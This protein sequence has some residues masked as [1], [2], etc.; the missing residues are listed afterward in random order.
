MERALF[1][2][3]EK[4]VL[5]AVRRA[6]ADKVEVETTT[7]ASEALRL[8]VERGP[9]AVVVSELEPNGAD[10][11]ELLTRAREISP[12]CVCMVLTADAEFEA[13][14]SV[15]NR[16]S[17]FRFLTKPLRPGDLVKAVDDALAQHRL[18]SSERELITST[19]SSSINALVE[20]LALVNPLAFGRASKIK[21]YVSHM[22][23]HSEIGEGWE[24]EMA[25]MLSQ[26]GCVTIPA[27][28]LKRLFAGQP[29]TEQE[30]SMYASSPEVA[31]SILSGIPRL[32][33]VA[34]MVSWQRYSL[35][36][37]AKREDADLE[38]PI[39]AG[40]QMLKLAHDYDRLISIGKR[41]NEA[42]AMLRTR[43]SVYLEPLLDALETLLDSE[44]EETVIRSVCV[45]DLAIGM[46]FDEDV[47]APNNVVLVGAGQLVTVALM[48]RLRNFSSGIGVNEPFRV[49]VPRMMQ[50]EAKEFAMGKE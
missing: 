44:D 28:S 39:V 41:H 46:T 9:F 3:G 2:D 23:K 40:A 42:I 4:T 35:H 14:L 36:D 31:Y 8:L 50:I 26:I 30:K 38:G 16:L 6:L 24:Y 15:V 45:D 12:E 29:V 13:A 34:T 7:D 37:L 49:R 17:L 11:G 25:A 22:A 19:L 21:H 10:G 33:R 48:K 1:I 27:D 47:T 18:I 5:H 20:V 43:R 32:D